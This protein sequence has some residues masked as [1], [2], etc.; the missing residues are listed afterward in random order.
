MA[1][2][3]SPLPLLVSVCSICLDAYIA[4]LTTAFYFYVT[5]CRTV[6]Y[7]NYNHMYNLADGISETS[8][9]PFQNSSSSLPDSLNWDDWTTFRHINGVTVYQQQEPNSKEATYMVSASVHATPEDCLKV[10]SPPCCPAM[11]YFSST[12][13]LCLCSRPTSAS[14]QCAACAMPCLKGL[15]D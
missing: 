1:L 11:H 5:L 2:T 6:G 15:Q 7:A 4:H 9:G 8:Q 10:C 13:A 3:R 12:V 14:E